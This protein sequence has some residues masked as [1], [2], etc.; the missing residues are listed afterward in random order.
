MDIA[1]NQVQA[2][3]KRVVVL[4][5]IIAALAAAVFG[6]VEGGWAALSAGYGG[7]TSLAVSWM[8]RRG[9]LKANEI[10]RDDPQRGMT[11]LYVGAVQRFVLVLAMLGLGL[12]LFKLAALATVIGFGCAQLAYAV[13]MKKSA[14]PASRK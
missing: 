2:N 14:H 13:V 10:A 6:V 11:A 5:L 7:L 9:V 3:A 8:L 4:Q 1:I 12:G